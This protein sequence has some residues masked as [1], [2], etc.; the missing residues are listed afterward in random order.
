[1]AP[2][3][4]VLSASYHRNPPTAPAGRNSLVEDLKYRF[5]ATKNELMAAQ[6]GLTPLTKITLK[7]ARSIWIHT[8]ISQQ[9]LP[10]SKVFLSQE[11]FMEME[12]ELRK[13]LS[14]DENDLVD[15]D[16]FLPTMV[17]LIRPKVTL[18]DEEEL[19]KELFQFWFPKNSTFM[20]DMKNYSM[21]HETPEEMDSNK[22]NVIDDGKPNF[23]FIKKMRNRKKFLENSGFNMWLD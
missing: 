12:S 22:A 1:V 13:M 6:E 21:K 2:S 16:D 11:I 3:T 15:F 8:L 5:S 7:D 10:S 18:E 4:K 20:S 23:E 14:V 19:T 17:C 9:G